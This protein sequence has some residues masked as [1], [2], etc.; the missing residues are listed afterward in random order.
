MRRAIPLGSPDAA[1]GRRTRLAYLVTHPIQYQAPLLKRLAAEPDIALKVFFRS[2]TT[3]RGFVDPGFGRRIEWDV[4]LLEGY[5]HEFL[6]TLGS[7]RL[8][9][10]WRPYNYGLVHRLAAGRFDALWVH[11]YARAYHWAAM[12]AAKRH[13]LTVLLRDEATPV[14]AS[15]GPVKRAAKRL[16]FRGL[17]R[18]C[19]GFLAIGS[20]NRDYYRSEGIPPDRIFLMPYAVDNARF[21]AAA[22]AAAPAREA[23][24]ASL[25]LP[26]GRPIL[27]FVGKLIPVKDPG[28]LIDALG[29]LRTAGAT[30]PQ[31]YLLFAGEGH[32]RPALQQQAEQLGVPD[33]VRFL[34][35]RNQSELPALYDLC[36]VLV[37]PSRREPWGLVVNEAMN[38]GRPVLVSTRVG[39][40]PDLVREGVNGYRLPPA[41]AAAWAGALRPMLGDPARLRAMGAASLEIIGNWG[42]EQ[43]IGGLRQALANLLPR[44]NGSCAF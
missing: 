28:L 36:D 14:S 27:L 29:L 8:S 13:G 15:R 5:E 42:F 2:D 21:R 9:P 30:D 4:P 10:V 23:L 37:L 40:G 31:P 16:F 39:A 25:G 18:V 6:P 43:D 26:A 11:G 22:A 3:V 12:A 1:G 20:L 35:F 17:R 38:A 44:R 24:R 19:D 41:D 34:G 33:R 7:R 32:L